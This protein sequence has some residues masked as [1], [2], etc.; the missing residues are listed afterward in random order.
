MR[1]VE[2]G[3]SS[4]SVRGRE[5]FERGDK[6]Y[7]IRV[8]WA[9]N[10]VSRVVVS[11]SRV[12]LRTDLSFSFPFVALYAQDDAWRRSTRKETRFLS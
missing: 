5:K 7:C 1:H 6:M 4:S 8:A 9:K 11:P 2:H 3:S 12:Q 10:K